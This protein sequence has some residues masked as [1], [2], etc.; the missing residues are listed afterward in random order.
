MPDTRHL[1]T[2]NVILKMAGA[3]RAVST[4]VVNEEEDGLWFSS[5]ALFGE[6][7]GAYPAI[8]NMTSPAVFVPFWQVQFLIVDG[9]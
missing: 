2:K 6:L 3:N 8:P 4:K 7:R 5:D 1:R 9:E